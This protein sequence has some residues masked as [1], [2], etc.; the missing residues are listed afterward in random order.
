MYTMQVQLQ[1]MYEAYYAAD[2]SNRTPPIPTVNLR[3]SHPQQRESE[4]C[5][6]AEATD[7]ERDA[8]KTALLNAVFGLEKALA[9]EHP[10]RYLFAC[11]LS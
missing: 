11:L 9:I 8:A 7:S 2:P 5:N 10:V 3:L 6:G 4:L 1:S